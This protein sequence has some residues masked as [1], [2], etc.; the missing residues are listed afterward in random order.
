MSQMTDIA[1]PRL[2]D[3]MQEGTI[4]AW[5]VED[6]Q[7]VS[8]GQDLVEI[9][10]DKATVAHASEADGVVQIV[11]AVGD[12]LPVGA[13]I[14]RV[15]VA[16][17]AP[18]ENDD[19]PAEPAAAEDPAPAPPPAERA[20]S[21]A[22]RNGDDASARLI[23]T[24][25]AR[26]IAGAHGIDP[27]TL[28]GSG[29]GGRITKADVLRA[30]GAE[31]APEPAVEPEPAVPPA[32]AARAAAPAPKPGTRIQQPSRLQQ[33]VARRM[34]EAGT[35]VPH[36]QVQTEVEADAALA[37]REELK[38]A[39]A[40]DEP[41]PSI[42]DLIVKACAL[43]LPAHP[44]V[45][46]SFAG[47]VYELHDHVHVG[48]AVAT[49]DGLVVATIRD[50]D[51]KALGVLARESRALAERVR[52]GTAT[53]A[54]LTGAT[55]S[56]SNL[57]M[58]GM[59]AITPLINPPQAAILGVGAVRPV[60]MRTEDG[61]IADRS[62]LTLTLSCDHRI[63]NGADASRFLLDVRRRLETPLRLVL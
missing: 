30:A 22:D 14:A 8:A 5:L 41:V 16:A 9:E 37:L 53:P 35:T 52:A 36:F 43:A 18:T 11:A 62:L 13:T 24:P 2:T 19:H 3:Q 38:G 31:A 4:V 26:R 27:G 61:G 44:L 40:E 21:G 7:A 55:F 51:Q 46:G 33:V 10:T 6:G 20:A 45:N 60:L 57:G 54:Q 59:T 15:G 47:G 58:F 17:A 48:I 42:N 12:T 28:C 56:V 49:E 63:L 1:M 34:A 29:L 25:L 32:P 50:A 39:A 23:V